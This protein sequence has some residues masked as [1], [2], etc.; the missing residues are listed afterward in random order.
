MMENTAQQIGT[1]FPLQELPKQVIEKGQAAE[2][3]HG[4]QGN[5]VSG[6]SGVEGEAEHQMQKDGHD[7]KRRDERSLAVPETGRR[8]PHCQSGA[9]NPTPFR[10]S[11]T[12]GKNFIT[13]PGPEAIYRRLS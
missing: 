10:L 12:G 3:E 13:E 7:G 8:I 2:S 5:L 11:V 4:Q 9:R 1:K 6:R